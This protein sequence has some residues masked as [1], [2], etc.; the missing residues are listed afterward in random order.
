GQE[1]S[2]A[3]PLD[4]AGGQG[5]PAR[6]ARRVPHDERHRTVPQLDVPADERS[7]PRD[8][9]AVGPS[10]RRRHG[11]VRAR[12]G[13]A[14]LHHR[15]VPRAPRPGRAAP[16]A[17]QH[18]AR[19]P[20]DRDPGADPRDDRD[21]HRPHD[22]QDAG[23]GGVGR[24]AGGGGGAPVVVGVPL[25]AVHHAQPGD[26]QGRHPRHGERALPAQ[27]QDGELR[28]A[29]RGRAALVLDP[30]PGRQA[31]PH[32]QPHELPLVHPRLRG[33]HGAQRELQR[34]LRREPR[35]HEVP[36][37]RR[38]HGAVRELD[39]RAAPPGGD[40][41]QAGPGGDAGRG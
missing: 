5:C 2:A 40:R 25:P 12:R 27:G 19:D 1:S 37:L 13:D 36:D 8:R 3:S 35:E 23:E 31:R 32:R 16:R 30:A 15:Q 24:A 20:L 7:E 34:V 28:A 6:A 41:R 26:E 38:G 17:R 14:D 4:R 18:H 29:H 21:P 9:L 11:G 22:L 10:A 33:P 39:G